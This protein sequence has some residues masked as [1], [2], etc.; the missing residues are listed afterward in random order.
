MPPPA[1]DINPDPDGRGL[2]LNISE[3]NNSLSF[4]RAIEVVPHFRLEPVQ[5]N[6]IPK[7]VSSWHVAAS[8]KGFPR[9]NQ[10]AMVPAFQS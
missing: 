1:Y 2:T 3:T 5:E 9:S 8:K 4:D 10:E 7:L 6:A